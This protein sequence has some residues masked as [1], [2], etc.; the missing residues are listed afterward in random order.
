VITGREM[1]HDQREDRRHA[2]RRSH[3]SLGPFQRCE[4]L[5]EGIDGRVGEARVDVA[6]FFARKAR[7]SLRRAVKDEAGGQV[8]RLGVFVEL[9][10]CGAGANSQRFQLILF[11][12]LLYSADIRLRCICCEAPP[13]SLSFFGLPLRGLDLV[14]ILGADVAGDIAAIEARGIEGG[15]TA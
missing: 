5:L 2:A 12:H 4:A 3:G 9:A 11:V 8:E 15:E 7:S 13:S 10:A 1:G 6:V 14:E